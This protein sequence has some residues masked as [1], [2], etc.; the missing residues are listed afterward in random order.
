MLQRPIS[1]LSSR[2]VAAKAQ[3]QLLKRETVKVFFMAVPDLPEELIGVRTKRE[4]VVTRF[5]DVR[6]SRQELFFWDRNSQNAPEKSLGRRRVG[7]QFSLQPHLK[8][9]NPVKNGAPY[10]ACLPNSGH[11][12]R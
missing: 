12:L 1:Q 3:N 5:V 4:N 11:R 9:P 8:T 7:R 10:V 2:Y 6:S